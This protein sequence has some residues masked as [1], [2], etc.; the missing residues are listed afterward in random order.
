MSRRKHRWYA[1]Y[2]TFWNNK[3]AYCLG[4]GNTVDHFI[5]KCF[6][7]IG[8]DSRFNKVL[9]CRSCN[10]CK[11]DLHP[12]VWCSSTQRDHIARYMNAM[13]QHCIQE[14]RD[15]KTHPKNLL[16]DFHRYRWVRKRF[17]SRVIILSM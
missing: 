7:F 10:Q 5:P 15:N 2:K 9:S 13:L 11:R 17:H 3:C 6:H 16:A 8:V 14:C 1:L 4:S 12:N